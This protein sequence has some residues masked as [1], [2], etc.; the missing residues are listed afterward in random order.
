M[1][2][3]NFHIL[4]HIIILPDGINKCASQYVCLNALLIFF[5]ISYKRFKTL[6]EFIKIGKT[7]GPTHLLVGS[8]SNGA[9]KGLIVE[10]LHD[11]FVSLQRHDT[12]PHATKVVRTTTGISLRNDD[13][14]A[15]LPS[16]FTKR[17]MYCNFLFGLG[18]CV[19]PKGNGSFGPLR[20]YEMRED[21]Y[22]WVGTA[23]TQCHACCFETFI[24]FWLSHYR[25]Y[26][27]GYLLMIRAQLV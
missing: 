16:S 4:N 2:W 11:N 21:S 15:E 3:E 6:E 8:K 18:W 20:E 13:D 5:N 22:D 23:E 27:L 10:K 25:E 7:I 1:A 12:K 19:K 17:Q 14:I 24:I 9:I 26:K